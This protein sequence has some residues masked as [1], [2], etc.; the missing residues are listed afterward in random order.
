[1]PQILTYLNNLKTHM[2]NTILNPFESLILENNVILEGRKTEEITVNFNFP[3]YDFYLGEI[4]LIQSSRKV[5][6]EGVRL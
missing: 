6:D 1:M 5:L 2:V 4:R 3:I